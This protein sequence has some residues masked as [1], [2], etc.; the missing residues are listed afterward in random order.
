MPVTAENKKPV[1]PRK[2]ILKTPNC[3]VFKDG[4]FISPT[5]R[6]KDSSSRVD[7][8]GNTIDGNKKHRILINLTANCTVLVESLKNHNKKE[9]RKP[10]KQGCLIF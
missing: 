1:G 6:R 4:C 3:K 9:Y 2:S 8:F 5:K 10:K 7:F